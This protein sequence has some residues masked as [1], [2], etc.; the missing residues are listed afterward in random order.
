MTVGGVARH[1]AFCAGM[2]EV[3]KIVVN[4]RRP[5]PAGRKRLRCVRLYIFA[6]SVYCGAWFVSPETHG[7]ENQAL[8]TKKFKPRHPL[9]GLDNHDRRYCSGPPRSHR[10]E[11]YRHPT[12]QTKDQ[13]IAEGHPDTAGGGLRGR[14]SGKSGLSPVVACKVRSLACAASPGPIRRGESPHRLKPRA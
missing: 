13:Q 4:P 2:R 14:R 5:H 12:D 1:F 3:S 9:V 8:L 6:P 11:P 10:R 7:D